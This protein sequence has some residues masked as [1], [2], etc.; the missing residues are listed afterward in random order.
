MG[1]FGD[2]YRSWFRFS[3]VTIPDGSTILSAKLRFKASV[4]ASND[5]CNVNIYIV[6][7]DDPSAPANA[8]AVM[9]YTLGDAQAWNSIAHWTANTWYD[10][11]S[12]VTILQDHIDTVNWAS[13]QAL[14]VIVANNADT[15]ASRRCYSREGGTANSTELVVSYE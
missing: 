3:N 7:E 10:S 9:G 6:E 8:A 12:L 1:D 13:G 15:S 4:A 11:P 14:I 5:T 2:P